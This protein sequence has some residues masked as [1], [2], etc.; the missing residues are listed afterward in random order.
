MNRIRIG[1]LVSMNDPEDGMR[2]IDTFLKH[3][4][5]SFA[6]T[7]WRTVGEVDLTALAARVRAKLDPLGVPVSCLSIF[8]NPLGGDAEAADAIHSWERVIDAAPSFGCTIVRRLESGSPSKTV[9]WMAIGPA[10]TGTSLSTPPRG[11]CSSRPCQARPSA[12]NGNPAT[13][14]SD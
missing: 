4:F 14:S 11:A 10:A 1:T 3:G 6:L 5:E 13:S 2:K 12:S 8:G 7:F 9:R